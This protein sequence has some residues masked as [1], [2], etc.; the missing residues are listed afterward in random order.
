M[1]RVSLE[2]FLCLSLFNSKRTKTELRLNDVLSAQWLLELSL[3]KD[4]LLLVLFSPIHFADR[5]VIM[6][7]CA[8]LFSFSPPSSSMEISEFRPFSVQRD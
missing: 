7:F 6:N 2:S 4:H 1:S 8:E 5:I 3:I